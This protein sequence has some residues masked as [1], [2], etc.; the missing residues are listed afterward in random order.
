MN[1]LLIIGLLLVAILAITFGACAWLRHRKARGWV[2]MANIAEGTHIKA[3][4]RLTDAAVSIRF[5]LAK[6]GSDEYH[7]DICGVSDMPIAAMTD[8]ADAAEYDMACRF[9]GATD[10]TMKLVA[11]AAI[12]DGD[13]VSP[14]AAGKVRTLPTV[15]GTYWVVGRSLTNAAADLDVIEIDPCVPFQV[16]VVNAASVASAADELPIPITHLIVQKT[17]G[18]DLEECTLA[19][20]LVGQEITVILVVDG[21]G[22]ASITPATKTGFVSVTLVGAGDGVTFK[23]DGATGWRIIG[24]F[25][26]TA[27]VELT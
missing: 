7:V 23:W 9:F 3:R 10:E 13:W 20:G 5:L 15:P 16:T 12:A 2:T 6:I 19:D 11:S 24:T 1:H 14:A 22:N 4:Q 25:G 17:T 27:T 8:E 18:A 21:G 26:A